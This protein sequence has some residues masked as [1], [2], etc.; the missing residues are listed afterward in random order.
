MKKLL[1]AIIFFPS[2]SYA[3]DVWYGINDAGTKV[4]QRFYC[5]SALG[6]VPCGIINQGG[7]V[8]EIPVGG[9]TDTAILDINNAGVM[10]GQVVY[11]TGSLQAAKC[12]MAGCGS[13]SYLLGNPKSS[14]AWKINDYG[15]ILIKKTTYSPVTR[16]TTYS[17]CLLSGT[18]CSLLPKQ[19]AGGY[20]A[21]YSYALNNLGHT[22]GVYYLADQAHGIAF[23]RTQ[24]RSIDVVY[25]GAKITTIYGL[26]DAGDA[27]GIACLQTNRD[28]NL[29]GA[30][31]LSSVGFKYRNGMFETLPNDLRDINNYGVSV[32]Q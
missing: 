18:V 11:L 6:Q 16:K 19:S 3:V 27:S 4:G 7:V 13:I 22:G 20:S 2:I 17:E 12:S 30:Q 24:I 15:V 1:F 32:G 29:A 25:P 31:C 23:I 28:F 5:A 8:S 9:W 26:N 21:T 10:V 14:T